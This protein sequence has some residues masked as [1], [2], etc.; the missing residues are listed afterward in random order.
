MAAAVCWLARTALRPVERL[1]RAVEHVARTEDLSVT[2]P[3]EGEDE[4]A[5]LS[6]SFN[7]MTAALSSSQERQRRLVATAPG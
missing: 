6:R 7:T 3:V 4:I 5:R 1:T 2:I